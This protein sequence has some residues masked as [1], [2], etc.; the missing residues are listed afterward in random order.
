MITR[1]RLLRLFAL[2]SFAT[3]ALACGGKSSE[4]THCDSA[5]ACPSGQICQGTVCVAVSDADATAVTSDAL[6]DSGLSDVTPPDSVGTGDTPGDDSGDLLDGAQLD[7]SA[8]DVSEVLSAPPTISMVLPRTIKV[9]SETKT[10]DV[11]VIR[12]KNFPTD[13]G[14]VKVTWGPSKIEF[15]VGKIGAHGTA[16]FV[17]VPDTALTEVGSHPIVVDTAAGNVAS[18]AYVTVMAD[19]KLG[20]APAATYGAGLLCSVYRLKAGTTKMPDLKGVDGCAAPLD[21]SLDHT[22]S[23]CPHTTIAISSFDLPLHASAP[24]FPGTPALAGNYAIRCI[25]QLAI[26]KAGLY[27]LHACAENGALLWLGETLNLGGVLAKAS[28]TVDNDGSHGPLCK[29]TVPPISLSI[30]VYDVAVSFIHG[31]AGE[32]YWG[33]L[34][35]L[36]DESTAEVIPFQYFIPP[37]PYQSTTAD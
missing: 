7:G 13:P 11:L 18:A 25:G 2:F 34:W 9:C 30:G 26:P 22:L 21:P 33:L 32:A 3:A 16:L 6:T 5:V 35:T 8:D 31:P 14:Q 15:I 17:H 36:P 29:W 12:G 27:T 24:V 19:Q 37:A 10:S 23:D 28:A 20:C 1:S 4:Q